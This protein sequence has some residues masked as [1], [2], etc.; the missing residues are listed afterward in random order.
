MIQE[1][2]RMFKAMNLPKIVEH[3]YFFLI[4]RAKKLQDPSKLPNPL[5]INMLLTLTTKSLIEFK[6]INNCLIYT[7][8]IHN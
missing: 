4:R 2:K 3:F 1:N 6:A 5:L 8:P 7:N